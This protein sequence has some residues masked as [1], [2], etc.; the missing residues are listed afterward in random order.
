MV[1]QGSEDPREG[2]REEDLSSGESDE[3]DRRVSQRYFAVIDSMYAP[4]AIYAGPTALG[5]HYKR[6]GTEQFE[7]ATSDRGSVRGFERAEDA[8]NFFFRNFNRRKIVEI[9]R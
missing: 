6:G 2:L 3:W 8:I 9:R 4:P 5:A 1:A 7:T